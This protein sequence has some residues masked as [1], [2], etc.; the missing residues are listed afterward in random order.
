MLV[1]GEA[2][3]MSEITSFITSHCEQSK[4]FYFNSTHMFP[5]LKPRSRVEKKYKNY[6]DLINMTLERFISFLTKQ[7]KNQ[8]RN[9]QR[10]AP[11]LL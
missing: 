3:C 10:G 11:W 9:S 5:S 6:P 7:Y 8:V 2:L 4:D 1:T